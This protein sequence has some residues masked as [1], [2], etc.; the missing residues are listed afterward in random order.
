M[1]LAVPMKLIEV[2]GE[3]GVAE[4]GGVT[5]PV[6]L[7]LLDDPKV[8]DYVI[9]HAGFAIQT[10]DTEEAQERLKLFAEMAEIAEQDD[11]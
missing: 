2:S 3:S 6:A 1:C 9:V 7:Q 11:H 8:G 5:V 4:S 10:I